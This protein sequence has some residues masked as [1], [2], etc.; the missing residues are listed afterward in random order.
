MTGQTKLGLA[1]VGWA[2]LALGLLSWSALNSLVVFDHDG[3]LYN[4]SQ[5]DGFDA[6]IADRLGQLNPSG[7]KTV[8]HFE[9]D[10]CTCQW[11]AASHIGSVRQLASEYGYHNLNI[12]LQSEIGHSLI[13]YIPATPAIAVIDGSGALTYIGPYSTGM[14]CSAGQGLVE[15]FIQESQYPA[16]GA[17]IPFDASGCYCSNP[18]A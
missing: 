17:T 9:S 3:R 7:K 12:N 18:I 14:S 11:V 8:I 1:L 2:I 13:E 15:R 10:D 5:M 4:A 16:I 6:V